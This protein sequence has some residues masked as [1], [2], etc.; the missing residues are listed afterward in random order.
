MS[1]HHEIGHEQEILPGQAVIPGQ[2][3]PPSSRPPT[4][5]RLL[6]AL[7]TI[8]IIVLLMAMSAGIVALARLNQPHVTPTPGP[9]AT[10][11]VTPTLVPTSTAQPTET[12]LPPGQWVQVLTDYRVTQLVAAP[13]QPNVVYACAI[14]PGVPI[15]YRSVETVLRSA[16]FGATW[17]DIGKRAQMSR[18][19]E[20]AVNP[21]DSYEIVVATSSNPPADE[22]VPSY[23]LE[24]TTNGGDTWETIH[25]MVEVPGLNTAVAWQGMSLRFAGNRLWSLQAISTS[26]TPAPQGLQVAGR[27][28]T[29]VDGGHTWT[30]L[31][32]RLA[33][34]G[35]SAEAYAVA[36]AQ[37]AVVYE[38]AYVPVVPGT[39]PPPLELYQS[40]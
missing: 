20:L 26:L 30:V 29:S 35:R 12:P 36:L 11:A 18:G 28:I 15:E 6:V 31:D 7:V 25:P 4:R 16:D 33:A 14:A 21:T 22:T 5:R 40:V 9:S 17:Q 24:H 38:L 32:T 37:P 2:P 10:T 13:S 39:A 8:I 23:V 3:L 34:S 27:V 19:C 1:T